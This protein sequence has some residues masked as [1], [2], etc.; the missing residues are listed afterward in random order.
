M[1][2]TKCSMGILIKL[3]LFAVSSFLIVCTVQMYNSCCV[4]ASQCIVTAALGT[5]Q[6]IV[7]GTY[8]INI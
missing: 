1:P 8:N 4:Y 3:N 7:T 2:L 5:V 6:S